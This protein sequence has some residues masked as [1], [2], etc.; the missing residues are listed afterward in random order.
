MTAARKV[1]RE[2]LAA[3]IGGVMTSAQAV[4]DHKPAELEGSPAVM[5]LSAGSER[6][7]ETTAGFG[8]TFFFEIHNLVLYADP[9]AGWTEE[10]A[11]DALDTLEYEL[12]TFMNDKAN[13][14]GSYWKTIRYAGRSVIGKTI[15]GGTEY[16]DEI[17]PL[18]VSC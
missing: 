16:Q 13:L 3:A 1:V 11:E 9:K 2:Q 4:Y 17:V 15:I 12:A 10:D 18:V 6:R 7:K 5:V 8:A 14:K